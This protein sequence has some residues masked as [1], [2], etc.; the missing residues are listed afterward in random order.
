MTVLHGGCPCRCPV[1]S[2]VAGCMSAAGREGSFQ[3]SQPVADGRRGEQFQWAS[4]CA[5]YTCMLER[6]DADRID[7]VAELSAIPARDV[8]GL[9]I[10]G[11]PRRRER[12]GQVDAVRRL[13]LSEGRAG[14]ERCARRCASGRVRRTRQS[15]RDRPDRHQRDAP[16]SQRTPDALQA[17]DC[18]R[19]KQTDRLSG[20]LWC[21]PQVRRSGRAVE[22]LRVL[23]WQGQGRGGRSGF[24]A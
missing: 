20:G 13:G 4:S 16:S 15:R 1:S 18:E 7:R 24:V 12:L 17:R 19:G 3:D 2:A 23:P 10:H 22:T 9:A 8:A 14:G 6:P 21:C 5:E 11:D